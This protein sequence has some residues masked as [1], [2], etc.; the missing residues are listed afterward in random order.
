MPNWCVGDLK[1]RGETNDITRFLTECIEGCEF[2]IDEL[3]TL[4]I[5]NIRGQVI[6]GARR[7]FCDNPNEII[8]GYELEN[9]YIVV[10]PISA[11]WVLSP[12]EMIELSKKFNVDFRFY[13]F[14][15]GN[16]FNQELEII[17]GEL[18]LDKCIEFKNYI[19]ECPMPYL[20][21]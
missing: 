8:E 17:K 5:K 7:V 1:I 12:P 16:A 21:G 10:V 18:T 3:G 20:G 13:G 19:W 6:K 14:E 9:G 4:E 2:K 15:W 11:A